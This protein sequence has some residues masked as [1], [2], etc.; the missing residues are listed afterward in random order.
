MIEVT[1]LPRGQNTAD[2]LKDIVFHI[3]DKKLMKQ[4][5]R[6]LTMI[7]IFERIGMHEH[8]FV[9]AFNEVQPPLGIDPKVIQRL[10]DANDKAVLDGIQSLLEQHLTYADPAPREVYTTETAADY[11]DMT[12]D[13]IN[14]HQQNG[15]LIGRMLGHTRIYTKDE[16]DT[17]RFTRR[18]AGR[19]KQEI[20]ES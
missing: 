16:L 8:G 20:V 14:Y 10:P 9:K 5:H 1:Q 13:G 4:R 11:L 17:F 18:P 15:N 3:R 6:I 7:G 19:P 2:Y 12:K